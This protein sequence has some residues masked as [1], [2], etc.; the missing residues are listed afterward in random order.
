MKAFGGDYIR[1]SKYGRNDHVFLH[2]ARTQI[3]T[4]DEGGNLVSED[5]ASSQAS[6]ATAVAG[7]DGVAEGGVAFS[8]PEGQLIG[9][10]DSGVDVVERRSR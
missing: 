3:V 2:N 9:L 8:E 1:H 10:R 5:L 6:L 7:S 4:A